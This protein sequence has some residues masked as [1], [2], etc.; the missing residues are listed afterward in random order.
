MSG[1]SSPPGKLP[2]PE[3]RETDP[4]TLRRALALVRALRDPALPGLLFLSGLAAL[5][6]AALILGWRG[7]AATPYVPLQVPFAVSGG[8]VGVAV[9]AVG[10]L[11]AS[12][13]EE[14]RDRARAAGEVDAVA[15]EIAEFARSAM[16]THGGWDR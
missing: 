3:L 14:R 9:V 16:R 2:P 6:F 15:L 8:L 10:A 7:A 4:D 12:V 13:L 11:L 5:G 1:P